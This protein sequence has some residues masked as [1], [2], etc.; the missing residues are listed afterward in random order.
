MDSPDVSREQKIKYRK[1][2][3]EILDALDQ[4]DPKAYSPIIVN[5]DVDATTGISEGTY[6]R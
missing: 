3:Q 6:N 1:A 5:T 2:E 4:L